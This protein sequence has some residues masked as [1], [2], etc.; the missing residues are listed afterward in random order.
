MFKI[1]KGVPLPLQGKGARLYPFIE[2][3]V[4]DSFFVE[5]KVPRNLHQP[6]R[7][8]CPGR[9]FVFRTRIENDR[10]GTRVWRVE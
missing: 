1:D 4:G 2:L 3:E 5:G 8:Q 7:Q 10:E 6:A 9:K